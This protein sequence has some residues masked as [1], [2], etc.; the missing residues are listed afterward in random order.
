MASNVTVDCMDRS[1][2]CSGKNV[3]V[4]PGEPVVDNIT[5]G[6]TG[7]ASLYGGEIFHYFSVLYEPIHL[8]L[9]LIICLFG[10]VANTSNVIVLTRRSMITPTNVILTGLSAAQL[11]LLVNY[12]FL[13]TFNMCASNCMF[14]GKQGRLTKTVLS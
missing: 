5:N 6:S 3:S 7:H 12:L 8:P 10:V 14:P 9:S 13:L 4:T 1:I 11:F 2:D